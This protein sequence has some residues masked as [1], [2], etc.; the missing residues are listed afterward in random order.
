MKKETFLYFLPVG[1]MIVFAITNFIFIET[2]Y[3][4]L[5]FILWGICAVWVAV[6]AIKLLKK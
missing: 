5:S 4:K 3:F 2:L 1:L 6:N